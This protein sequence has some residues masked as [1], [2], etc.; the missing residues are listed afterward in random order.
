MIPAGISREH[1][2]NIGMELRQDLINCNLPPYAK[3]VEVA[4]NLLSILSTRVIKS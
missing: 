1:M 3:K 4:T 2:K